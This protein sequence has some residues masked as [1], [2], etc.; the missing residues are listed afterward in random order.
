MTRDDMHPMPQLP[1]PSSAELDSAVDHCLG[2]N[3]N[4]VELHHI[5]VKAIFFSSVVCLYCTLVVDIT[6]TQNT[7]NREK[8]C[9]RLN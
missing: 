7:Q 8:S 1:A 5:T 6:Q 3:C 2:M 9:E 4:A